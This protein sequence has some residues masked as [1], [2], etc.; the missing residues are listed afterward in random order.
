MK[1]KVTHYVKGKKRTR[2][3]NKSHCD[4]TAEDREILDRLRWGKFCP[5]TYTNS[6][7]K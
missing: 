7:N 5:I 2:L 3:V 6:L 4:W 1:T